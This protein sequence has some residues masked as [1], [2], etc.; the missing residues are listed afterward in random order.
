M[1]TPQESKKEPIHADVLYSICAI[2]MVRIKVTTGI[3]EQN[4]LQQYS[5]VA[6]LTPLEAL[7]GVI[8]AC[9]PVMKPIFSKLRATGM[10]SSFWTRTP[11]ASSCKPINTPPSNRTAH[12]WRGGG[13]YPHISPPRQTVHKDSVHMFPSDLPTDVRAPSIPL[14]NFSWRPLSTFYLPKAEWE[15]D[16]SELRKDNE[17]GTTTDWDAGRRLSEGDSP[18]LP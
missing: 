1:S 15:H 8:N 12:F 3:D 4:S 18:T 17:I 10:F 9:L 14:P 6:L 7:L 11:T 5:K 16:P 2:T 13:K